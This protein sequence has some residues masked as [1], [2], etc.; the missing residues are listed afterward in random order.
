MGLPASGPISASQIGDYISDSA[1]YNLGQMADLAGFSEPDKMSDFYSYQTQSFY[2]EYYYYNVSQKNST[3]ACSFNTNAQLF[4]SNT[5]DN[6]HV[7]F[8]AVGALLFD[9]ADPGTASP[10]SLTAGGV[11]G[12][13][14]DASTSVSA[15]ISVL[16]SSESGYTNYVSN[17]FLCP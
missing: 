10:L 16:I 4:Y 6:S 15:A 7:T 14:D 3:F 13:D 12:I 11:Y 5:A 17:V 8:P 1:P 2:N 9:G